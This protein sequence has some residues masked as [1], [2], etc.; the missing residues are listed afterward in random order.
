[1]DQVRKTLGLGP[2]Q[3]DLDLKALME[4]SWGR[5]LMWRFLSEAGVNRNPYTGER[6]A[7]DFRCGEM[8]VGQRW[9][10]E[11]TRVCPHLYLKM[12]IEHTNAKDAKT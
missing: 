11:I 7:T 12:I 9:L 1:M 10:A 2:S 3:A 5:R 6:G 8:N 4:Q